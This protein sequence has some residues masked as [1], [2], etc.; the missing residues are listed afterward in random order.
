MIEWLSLGYIAIH[1]KIIDFSQKKSGREIIFLMGGRKP[2][3]YLRPL[4]FRWRLILLNYH[5]NG[6]L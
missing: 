1:R 5:K 4:H 6:L 3:I 2:L